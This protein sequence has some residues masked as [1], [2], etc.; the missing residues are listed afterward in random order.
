[1]RRAARNDEEVAGEGGLRGRALE[2]HVAAALGH[3]MIDHHVL[4]LGHVPGAQVD[5]CRRAYAPGRSELG[6]EKHGA[7]ETDEPQHV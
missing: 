3:K 4:R 6:V 2:D 7:G 1:V 5:A